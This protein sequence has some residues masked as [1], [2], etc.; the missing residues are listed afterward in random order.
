MGT[1]RGS[2]RTHPTNASWRP[3][4]VINRDLGGSVEGL[5][6]AGGQEQELLLFLVTLGRGYNGVWLR[7][8][9]SQI[10]FS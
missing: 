3:Q 2:S 9:D 1:S 8:A 4:Q 10:R 6:S 7:T 5:C